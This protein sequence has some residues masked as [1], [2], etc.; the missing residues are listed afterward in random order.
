MREGRRAARRK[1]VCARV[2]LQRH[3]RRLEHSE[4]KRRRLLFAQHEDLEPRDERGQPD[5][6]EGEQVEGDTARGAPPL[7]RAAHEGVRAGVE[8]EGGEE[9]QVEAQ[10]V[11]ERV[12]RDVRAR[13]KREATRSVGGWWEAARCETCEVCGGRARRAAHQPPE[14]PAK[15]RPRV[16][17]V[18]IK[19]VRGPILIIGRTPGTPSGPDSVGY[20][21]GVSWL[22]RWPCESCRTPNR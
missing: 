14:S 6:A 11:L 10:Q 1:G 4:R 7:R 20:R 13:A 19:K 17:T 3:A 21:R 16:P 22:R 12:R 5:D 18:K 2:H 8:G 9:R 15:P